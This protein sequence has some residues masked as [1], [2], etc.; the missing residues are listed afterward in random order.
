M[1]AALSWCL[2]FPKPHCVATFLH[3]TSVHL[4]FLL[5]HKWL[6]FF[7]FSWRCLTRTMVIGV[8]ERV[9]WQ[10]PKSLISRVRTCCILYGPHKH[11][12]HLAHTNINN[13]LS[14]HVLMLLQVFASWALRDK[15]TTQTHAHNSPQHAPIFTPPPFS[16]CVCMIWFFRHHKLLDVRSGILVCHYR[17]PVLPSTRSCIHLLYSPPMF[18]TSRG[19]SCC[20]SGWEK[21]RTWLLPW[22]ISTCDW[23]SLF[24]IRFSSPPPFVSSEEKQ[25]GSRWPR[26]IIP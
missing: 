25:Q 3:S 5:S 15:A 6:S 16:S 11:A 21:R 12:A 17:S 8:D 1:S 9:Y 4:I 7:S 18:T 23:S 26:C 20:W 14:K 13:N 24:N 10:A 22:H 19:C 2:L